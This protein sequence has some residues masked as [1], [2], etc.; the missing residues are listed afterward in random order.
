VELLGIRA[1]FSQEREQ[2]R[3]ALGLAR[4]HQSLFAS[5]F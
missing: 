4:L 3:L 5:F 2:T 1:I